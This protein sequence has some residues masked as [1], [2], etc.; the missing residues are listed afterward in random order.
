MKSLS[1]Y[2]ISIRDVGFDFVADGH[3]KRL[4][5]TTNVW[6]TM[7]CVF[8]YSLAFFKGSPIIGIRCAFI[9]EFCKENSISV[10][11]MLF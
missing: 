3:K 10:V 5:G 7:F 1:Q 4:F 11:E 2:P 6:S 9:H 8:I